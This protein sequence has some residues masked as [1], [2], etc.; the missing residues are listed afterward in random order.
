MKEILFFIIRNVNRNGSK[1][2]DYNQ[3]QISNQNQR[4]VLRQIVGKL[5]GNIHFPV[6]KMLT[7]F[8]I[9]WK[10]A[11]KLQEPKSYENSIVIIIKVIAEIRY[12]FNP[13]NLEGC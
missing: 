7:L 11:L 3:K 1:T 5:S 6:R 12:N 9:G 8:R 2:K 13:C 4:K 10:Q